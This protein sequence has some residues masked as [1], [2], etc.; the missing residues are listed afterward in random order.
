MQVHKMAQ[1]SAEWFQKR[2][3]AITGTILKNIMGTPKARQE[4]IYEAIANRLTVGNDADTPYES[5]MDRGTRLEPDAISVFEFETNKKVEEVGFCEND[6]EPQIAQSPD[7]Y[8]LD[9]DETEA[10][11]VKCMD[12]KNHVKMWLTNIVPPE[13][14]WQ[15]VQYFVVNDRL[16]KLYFAAYNPDIPTHK[17]HIIEINREDIVTDIKLARD[18]QKA[19]LLEV[20]SILQTLI[21]L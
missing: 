16:K 17:L 21:K 5:P 11:E 12:G 8:V 14:K 7:G 15:V 10:V 3:T 9:T 13:Y 19:F 20:N 6:E 18:N 1:R 2:K 4:A